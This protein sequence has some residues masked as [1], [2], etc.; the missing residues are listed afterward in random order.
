MSET[1]PRTSQ[2]PVPN[3]HPPRAAR[4]EQTSRRPTAWRR[5]LALVALALTALSC[6]GT[7]RVQWDAL[8]LR[9][10]VGGAVTR[11]SF[12]LVRPDASPP[13]RRPA[14]NED[15]WEFSAPAEIDLAKDGLLVKVAE[16]SGGPAWISAQAYDGDTLVAAGVRSVNTSSKT[17]VDWALSP[18]SDCDKDGDGARDC[19]VAGCCAAGEPA[20][21]DDTPGS[22]AAASPWRHETGCEQCDNGVDEDCD[23]A[24]STCTDTD[25]DGVA[26]C[27]EAACGPEAE[28]E[29]AV[30]PGATEICDGLDN[31]CDGKTD[32]D[33]PYSPIDP[34]EGAVTIGG[35]CGLGACAGGKAVCMT[36]GTGLYCSTQNNKLPKENCE[37]PADDDCDGKINE[38]CK[39]DDPDGDGVPSADE[40]AACAAPLASLHAEFHPGAKEG[41]CLTYTALVLQ[42]AP[43]WQPGKTIP[44]GA[45][46][47]QKMLEICDR[48]CDGKITPCDPED[49]D[50]DGVP[51]PLDCD[52]SDPLRYPGAPERCGDG[53]L[54]SCAGADPSCDTVEDKDK[55]GWPDDDDCAPDDAK[56]FPGAKELC[57]GLDDDCDGIAD[58]GSPEADDK[59]CAGCG[60]SSCLLTCMHLSA[61]PAAGLCTVKPWK[62]GTCVACVATP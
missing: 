19:A 32:E 40:D 53:V 20:D 12:A 57:N 36:N 38:G 15:G 54:Q 28:K 51:A 31:D 29:P 49:E 3:D 17:V 60:E 16:A 18:P 47:T 11:L 9:V 37:T 34:S 7:E 58:N 59:S 21:C 56:R 44:P 10:K 26:D 55:D 33:Q 1:A 25:K 4:R 8:Y 6:A 14:P 46:P 39:L 50:G 35:S 13:L 48:S 43:E 45:K 52:D 22:G 27:K 23:G 5:G 41:C 30:Y 24:D 62:D 2:S 61:A 42:L